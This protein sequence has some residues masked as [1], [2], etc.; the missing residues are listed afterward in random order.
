M[1]EIPKRKIAEGR[2]YAKELSMLFLSETE[3]LSLVIFN[4]IGT[5]CKHSDIRINQ[6]CQAS[7]IIFCFEDQFWVRCP[8]THSFPKRHF[9]FHFTPVIFN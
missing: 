5:L 1:K 3:M 4:R 8:C 7:N 2:D 6:I 9:F